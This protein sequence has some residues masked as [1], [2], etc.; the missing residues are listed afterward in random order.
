VRKQFKVPIAEFGGIQEALARAGRES[1][2]VIAGVE[3]MNA[4]VDNH[5]APMVLSSIMKQSCTDR[6]RTVVQD[7]MDILGGAGICRGNMNFL[8]NMYMSMPV[9]ITV[10]GANIMTRSFQ[11]IGQGLT[12]CHP[13]ILPLI[14]ALQDKANP[15]SPA[16]FMKQA[17]KVFGHVGA[18]FGL[19]ITRGLSSTLSTALRSPHAYKDS[20]KLLAYHEAQLLRLSANFAF[21]ADLALGLGGKAPHSPPHITLKSLL[22]R[23]FSRP[24]LT[25][26]ARM[27]QPDSSPH[28]SLI[29][30]GKLKFE[31]L[32]MGRLS[33]AMGAIFL[34]YA[35]LHHFSRNKHVEGL[36]AL[37]ESA[38]LNLECEAQNALRDA[39][40]NFPKIDG[41]IP[42]LGWIMSLGVAP[43][44]EL[45]RPYRPPGDELIKDVAKMMSTPSAVHDMFAENV[46]LG[47]GAT[48]RTRVAELIEA[49]PVCVEADAVSKR[50][51]VEKREP[52]AKESILLEQAV[53]L[54][55]TLIQVDVHDKVGSLEEIPKY[56]RPAIASTDARL[57]QGGLANFGAAQAA[58]SA[59]YTPQ[60]S[61]AVHEVP[62]AGR[63]TQ[64]AASS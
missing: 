21:T 38:M 30:L 58:G 31:E 9:A 34:G 1:Y 8:G 5:E 2:T 3:L 60:V 32:L 63:A 23:F 56:V 13:H 14:Y 57:K 52:T 35:T 62:Q 19:S 16:I 10:E 7:G 42:G 54:R 41:K 48:G 46:Y 55:D 6:G 25:H 18:N 47:E 33:D 51:R 22:Y 28:A 45:M 20:E 37:A 29:V 24:S 59:S 64:A 61:Q 26:S 27:S 40:Y 39:A 36:N 53:A 4:I 17:L 50:L 11:I 49:L 44:G 12:R 15:E 43:L